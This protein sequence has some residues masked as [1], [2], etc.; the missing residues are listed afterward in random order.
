V[1]VREGEKEGRGN[2]DAMP[3]LSDFPATPMDAIPHIA[4][5]L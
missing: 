1:K 3:F 2:E 4:P 5:T